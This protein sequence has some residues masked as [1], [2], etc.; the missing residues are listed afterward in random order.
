MKIKLIAALLA[1]VTAAGSS[2]AL[3]QSF[4]Y[5]VDPT[6]PLWSQDL[7]VPQF[8]PAFGTLTGVS[9]AVDASIAGS[10]YV[11]NQNPHPTQIGPYELG[12]GASVV[13]L[14]PGQ[15]QAGAGPTWY[16]P[17]TLL[18]AFDGVRDFAGADSFTRSARALTRD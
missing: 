2:S 4:S 12:N 7:Y 16:A 18:A 5:T 15:W 6:R 13:L 11:E 17:P 8:D 1:S 14:G 3:T 9:I 10:Q